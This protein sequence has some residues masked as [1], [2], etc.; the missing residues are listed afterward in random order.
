[1]FTGVAACR[2]SVPAVSARAAPRQ[3]PSA[4]VVAM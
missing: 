2:S 3:Q 4:K 1:M